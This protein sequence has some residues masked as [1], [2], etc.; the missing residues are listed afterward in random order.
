LFSDEAVSAMPVPVSAVMR[1]VLTMGPLPAFDMP[2]PLAV[3]DVAA[4][5][6]GA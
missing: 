3:H 1:L 4:D 2:V 5:Q 6:P